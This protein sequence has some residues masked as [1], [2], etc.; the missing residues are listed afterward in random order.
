[1][2]DKTTIERPALEHAAR[3]LSREIPG[4]IGTDREGY[5]IVSFVETSPPKNWMGWPVKWRRK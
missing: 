5:I 2:S 4:L 3:L 1:M